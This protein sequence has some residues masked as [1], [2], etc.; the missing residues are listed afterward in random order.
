[1]PAADIAD[2]P[3]WKRDMRRNYP[4]LSSVTQGDVVGLLTVGSA[5]SPSPNLLAGEE[6]NKQL[7]AVKQEGEKG[8]SA[9]FESEKGTAVL[10]E[11]GLPP[12]PP[13]FG[14]KA[15]VKYE[16]GHTSYGEK[17]VHAIWPP[18]LPF[19][20]SFANRMPQLPLPKL[21]LDFVYGRGTPRGAGRDCI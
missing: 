13:A 8:L 10:A 14:T 16:I 4:K 3:Y 6:G 11:N 20:D 17:Y 21:C 7:V 12:L 15:D 1:M 9:Y 5:A 19:D 2:N 18:K